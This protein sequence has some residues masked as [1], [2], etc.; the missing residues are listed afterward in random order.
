MGILKGA[1]S[2][3]RYRVDGEPPEDFRDRYIQSLEEHAFRE[4]LS[5]GHKEE[6]AGWVQIHNLLDTSF[7]D[8]N[9]WLYNQYAIFALRVDK[10]VLPAK[11]FR[12][13]LEKRV[14][15]WCEE[16]KRE[17]CPASVR[18]ELKEA[19]ELDMLSRTLPRVALFEVGWN[20]ND[21]YVLFHNQSELAN[22]RFRKLFFRTFGMQLIP[23]DPLDFVADLPDLVESL[24]AS[25]AADMRV[26]GANA[27]EAT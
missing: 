6:R 21:G 25:G 18:T 19:L 4:A 10:K 26:H 2:V 9:R 22:D 17:R 3:R 13:H 11:L 20:I 23:H 27:Q 5:A 1:M 14:A 16:Q 7:L 15:Q 12:A 8:V 24:A